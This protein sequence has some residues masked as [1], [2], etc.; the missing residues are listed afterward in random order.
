MRP[1]SL[2]PKSAVATAPQR[3]ELFVN[4][5]SVLLTGSGSISGEW[6]LYTSLLKFG[7]NTLNSGAVVLFINADDNVHFA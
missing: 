1:K 7:I 2:I 6:G 3:C 4:Y 5:F